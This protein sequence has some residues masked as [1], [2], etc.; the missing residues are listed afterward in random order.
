MKSWKWTVLALS[1]GL[2]LS[3]SSCMSAVADTVETYL[4]DLLDTLLANATSS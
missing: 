3:V 4:P 1:G 2:L